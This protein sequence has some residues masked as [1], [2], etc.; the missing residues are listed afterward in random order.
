[1]PDF[2]EL[3]TRISGPVL[4]PTD[5]GFAAEVSPWN[6]TFPLT[7]EVAVGVTSAAD[8]AEAVT[9]ARANALRV[10]VQATGHGSHEA[11]TDGML[12][13][14]KRLNSISIDPVTRVATVGAGVPAGAIVAAG[15][16]HGL[17]PIG[18]S[19]AT[20]GIVGLVL[21]GGLGPLARSHGFCSD[22]VRGFE[23][24][25]AAG[26]IVTASADEH[27]ELFWALRGGKGGLGIVTELRLELAELATLYAG[28]LVYDAADIEPALRAWVDYTRD[29]DPRVT[30]SAAIM[31]LPD[32]PFIPEPIRGRT[33]L[34][35]RFAYPGDSAEGERLAAPLR[36]AAAVYLDQLA[37]MPAAN[38]A[39]IHNDPVNP[40]AGWTRGRM[41][42]AVD[43]D[44]ASI[45]LKHAGS[46]VEAPFVA[47]EVR[48]VGSATARDVAGGSAVGGR[49]PEYT[50]NVVGAPNPALYETVVPRAADALVA[51]LAPWLA[52]E[53]TINFLAHPDTAE[54]FASAWPADTF[55][56][57]TA[58]R[59]EADPTG[60]FA[61]GPH[62]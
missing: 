10:R 15:A 1:M 17:A 49:S 37:E 47:V 53:T 38:I 13:I 30:T 57:L 24:V 48:H 32:L 21:G 40:A 23:V 61:Y 9:F 31:R 11:I 55:A 16:E 50:F 6:L 51:D 33:L 62:S 43:Q 25:T 22:H 14:T 28:S 2:A 26:D 35:L 34:S 60:V 59:A 58:A 46:G 7:P 5:D 52:T 42:D 19:S 3:R 41:F 54:E 27:P 36:A 39:T 29:A 45:I 56:R 44:F 18:G 12:I 4:V 8:V 20:V